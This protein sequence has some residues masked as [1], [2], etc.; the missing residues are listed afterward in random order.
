M[1]MQFLKA[2]NKGLLEKSVEYPIY[3][4]FV[5]SAASN[6]ALVSGARALSEYLKAN[7]STNLQ[8]L[9]WTLFSRRTV[10]PLR[11]TFSASTIDSLSS[12][13]D[14]FA[15]APSGTAVGGAGAI[16]VEDATSVPILGIFTGQGAQWCGMG[17]ELIESSPFCRNVIQKLED[18][19]HA[20]PDRPAWSLREELVA[21][22]SA[23]RINEAE[24]S[25]PLCTAVQ[26]LLVDLLHVA[27]TS[28]TAVVGHSS[29][30]IGAAYAAGAISAE[31][32]ICIAYYR[33]HHAKLTVGS[34]DRRGAMM[35][36]ECSIEYAKQFCASP[37]FEGRICIAASN[38]SSSTTLSGDEDAIIEA[39]AIFHD[40]QKFARILKVDRA[41]HSHHMIPCWK[42]YVDSLRNCD[43][44]IRDHM[45]SSW[46]SSVHRGDFE[47][48]KHQLADIYNMQSPV[49]F[50]QAIEQ[51]FEKKSPFD[52]TIEIGPHPT[53]RSPATQIIRELG[54]QTSY[55]GTLS[56]NKD[57]ILT[58]S[59][60]LGHLWARLGAT[61][62]LQAYS[63][64]LTGE[65]SRT[66]LKDL[67]AY[68]WDHDQVYWHESQAS[69]I[70][71]TAARTPHELLGRQCLDGTS[72][73]VR[74]RNV[75]RPREVP[76]LYGHQLQGQTVFPA[77]GYV[78]MAFESIIQVAANQ[79]DELQL[80]E[81]S[82][83]I[84]R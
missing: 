17:R 2:T 68:C 56:R 43:I 28:F 57:S 19:L 39:Q 35:A 41:Y 72:E 67:P 26:I 79:A 84:I 54:G 6:R 73:L 51:A 46:F 60:C 74:W 22:A 66:I 44:R 21:D 30:E 23:S 48:H 69:H 61:V 40:Q 10:H 64:Q 50:S 34:G 75:L 42:S 62:D 13:L 71:R 37:L 15:E 70:L 38:S 31:D 29:G 9:A 83:M 7:P 24:L 82:D 12:E 49:L 32:A 1:H 53:L 45:R 20:L 63:E 18:R 81:V 65:N 14:K 27:G 76:W 5:L 8:D 11:V 4:P 47:Q 3:T 78:V 77:A 55:V 59:N 36:V 58:L 80:I 16:G 33:G 52:I 25:Q